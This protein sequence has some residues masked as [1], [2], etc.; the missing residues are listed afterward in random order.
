MTTCHTE[1]AEQR[2]RKRAENNRLQQI[3]DE[4]KRALW[5]TERDKRTAAAKSVGMP[6]RDNDL[7]PIVRPY[8][9]RIEILAKQ[10]FAVRSVEGYPTYPKGWAHLT[11]LPGDKVRCF[12]RQ[13]FEDGL[14]EFEARVISLNCDQYPGRPDHWSITMIETKNDTTLVCTTGVASPLRRSSL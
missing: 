8:E 9:N 11:P 12:P 1:I 3:N 10:D 5:T 14:P 2:K 6:A 7:R 4:A 13:N